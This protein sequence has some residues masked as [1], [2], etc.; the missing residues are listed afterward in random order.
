MGILRNKTKGL[1]VSTEWSI[2]QIF[3]GVT[4]S[5]LSAT[6]WRWASVVL[7]VKA[8]VINFFE[9]ELKNIRDEKKEELN[10]IRAENKK[11]WEKLDSKLENIEQTKI[12]HHARLAVLEAFVAT[13]NIVP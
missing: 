4:V 11:H 6:F 2:G 8:D 9:K 7:N 10:A 3:V 1:N 13:K 12:D 5:I